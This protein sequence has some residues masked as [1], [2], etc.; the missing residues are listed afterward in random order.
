MGMDVAE[1]SVA[2][3]SE[4]RIQQ[5]TAALAE[6]R[7]ELGACRESLQRSQ[8]ALCA[9]ADGLAVVDVQGRVTCLNPIAAHLTGWTESESL[10]RF[11]TEII[12]FTDAQGRSVNVLSDGFE[13]FSNGHV[14]FVSLRRRDGHIILVDGTVADIHDR[15]KRAIGSVVTFRN[16]TA[17]A[18]LTR[19]LAFHANH[20]PLTGLQNR[21]AFE[22]QL[23]RAISTAAEFGCRHALLYCDLDHFKVVND[24]G[25]HVAGDE[26]LRQ[27]AVLL[28]R[29]LREHDSLARLGGDEFAVLL[30]NCTT[31]QATMVAEKIRSAIEGFEFAW[32]GQVFR[33]GTS[34]GQIDFSDDETL[35]VEEIVGIADRMCYV[36]KASGRN[37]VRSTAKMLGERQAGLTFPPRPGT[38]IDSGYPH[39]E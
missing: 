25:G 21:R 11:L 15:D 39:F 10:G 8:S 12:R 29:Q 36:A 3:D 28:R 2:S 19:E 7:L 18:R 17:S 33:I 35:S 34:I 31:A 6:A 22:A 16:V 26:L 27:L 20:D 32:D 23:E 24:I 1:K 5:L 38:P 4:A 9:L 30:E 14:D 13:G 37:Q